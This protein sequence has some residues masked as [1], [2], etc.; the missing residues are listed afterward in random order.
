[1]S[2]G[3]YIVLSNAAMRLSSVLQ[4]SFVNTAA[5]FQNNGLYAQRFLTFIN[6]QP[7]LRSKPDAIPAPS[8]P[9]DICFENVSFGYDDQKPI[10]QNLRFTIKA[11]ALMALVGHNGAGK[12]TLIKLLLRLYDVDSG[13]IT[14]GGVDIRDYDVE[15]YRQSIATVFQDHQIF[16]ATLAENVLMDEVKEAHRPRIIQSLTES[17]FGDRLATLPKGIDTVLT[18]EFD[19]N[20]VNLSCGEI[21]KV[22]LARMLIQNSPIAI[23][24]EPSSALDPI[25]EYHF[26]E[27]MY[28]HARGKT[29]IMISHRLSTTCMADCIYL[30]EHGQ[31]IESGNHDVLM[32]QGG[33]YAL[34]F[35]LQAKKYID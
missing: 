28:R 4:D 22:A 27:T 18:K 30:L 20:G 34:L 33:K 15:S 2:A 1:M 19:E 24:D 5:D 32:R 21:Q 9:M 23:L 3:D 35:N 25:A 26:N 14:L 16:S 10:F 7:L 6:H 17:G 31:I 29:V 12:T 8:V 11:G 13:R